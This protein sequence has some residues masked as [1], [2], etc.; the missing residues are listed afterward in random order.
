MFITEGNQDY[1]CFK[2]FDKFKHDP[3][4][5]GGVHYCLSFLRT[6]LCLL[7]AVSG[8]SRSMQA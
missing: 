3:T 8:F 5:E 2:I 1:N 4:V 6:F 7:L